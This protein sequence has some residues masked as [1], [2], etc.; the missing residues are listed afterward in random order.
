MQHVAVRRYQ[1]RDGRY[2][3]AFG[4]VDAVSI[5]TKVYDLYIRFADKPYNVVFGANTYRASGMIEK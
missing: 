3:D 1:C 5:L 2:A 4:F